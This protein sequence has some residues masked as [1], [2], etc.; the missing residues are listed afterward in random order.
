M[1]HQCLRIYVREGMRHDGQRIHDWLFE[2][3]RA[4]G[5]G[6][7]TVFRASA[8]FG[9]H[10]QHEDEFFELAGHLT[11]TVEFIGAPAQIDQFLSIVASVG[12]RLAYSTHPVRFGMT[13][14]RD[15]P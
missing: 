7:G 5:I 1:E 8:D 14:D 2:R 10:G 13:G 3:A 9:R 6:G 4:A 12:L 11:E 15:T